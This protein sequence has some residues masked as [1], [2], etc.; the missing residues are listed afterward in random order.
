[1]LDQ[2]ATVLDHPAAAGALFR[3]EQ[4]HSTTRTAARHR[5]T[6]RAGHPH[7]AIAYDRS[8]APDDRMRRIR[9]EFLSYDHP[10]V[11]K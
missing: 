9:G 10:E 6:A 8:L 4:Q 3:R 7:Q 5:R 11:D 1:V 2:A